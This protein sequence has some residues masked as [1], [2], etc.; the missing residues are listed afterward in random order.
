MTPETS[1]RN[2]Q[3]AMPNVHRVALGAQHQIGTFFESD[4]ATLM[5]PTPTE[6]CEAS[7]RL[8]FPEDPFYL[9]RPR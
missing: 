6:L 5:P 3:P 2:D 9:P 1:W 4:G 8:P 7:I